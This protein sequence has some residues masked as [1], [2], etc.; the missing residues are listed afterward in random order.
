MS[1]HFFGERVSSNL[2]C[3]GTPVLQQHVMNWF[4]CK[5]RGRDLDQVV[6]L[7]LPLLLWLHLLTHLDH[8]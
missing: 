7:T 4:Y 1:K 3:E 2:Y 5:N 6:L 8:F